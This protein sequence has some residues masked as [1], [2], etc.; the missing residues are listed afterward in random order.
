MAR[1]EFTA[2][3]YRIMKRTESLLIPG[4]FVYK[5]LGT[6]CPACKAQNR[7]MEHGDSI[8][9]WRCLS[10][11]SLWGNWLEVRE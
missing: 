10:R 11:L 6:V 5:N 2:S 4:K 7:A 8:I 3:D 1:I 9:C